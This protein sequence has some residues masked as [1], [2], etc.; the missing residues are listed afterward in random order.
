VCCHLSNRVF[1]GVTI[2]LMGSK[3]EDVPKEPV[4]KTV[5]VE[6]MNE[7]ELAT[8]VCNSILNDLFDWICCSWIFQP[9]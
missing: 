3:E 8:A 6:D 4:E 1:K 5:F 7:S 9:V 2:L